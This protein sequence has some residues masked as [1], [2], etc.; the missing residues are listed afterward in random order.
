MK[1]RSMLLI[2]LFT[3]VGGILLIVLNKRENLFEGLIIG[4]GILFIMACTYS[5]F[6]LGATY[7]RLSKMKQEGADAIAINRRKKFLNWVVAIPVTGGFLF[8]VLLL[9]MPVFFVN[10]L[11]YTFGV[12][13][14]IIGLI[15]LFFLL[16]AVRFYNLSGLW[17]IVSVLV[18]CVGVAV[19]I[20]GP[21]KLESAVT[22]LTGIVL[23][24]YS[25]NGFI[26]FIYRE[27]RLRQ[28]QL[29]NR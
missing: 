6:S 28:I 22:L 14:I 26:S 7:L 2:Y 25:V 21:E 3:L 5:L 11:I 8:G 24:C 15:Q 18:T 13:M 16:P 4:A 1:S 19:F 10:Y 9:A 20:V 17:L 23:V 29:L 27:S 12:V